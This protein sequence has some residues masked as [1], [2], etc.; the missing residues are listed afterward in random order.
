MLKDLLRTRDLSG[1]DIVRLLDLSAAYKAEPLRHHDTLHG[2]TVVQFFGKPSTRTR[3]SFETAIARLGGSAITTGP[4]DLQLGRG[5][6]IE[7]TARTISQYA[8]AFVIRT[9]KDDDVRR[10]AAAA[11]IPV[12]NALTD[13]HHPCQSLADLLTLRERFGDVTECR[14]AYVGDGYNVA[15]SLLEA[16]ALLGMDIA[17][18]TPPGYEPDRASIAFATA[19]AERSGA[20]VTITNDPA[21]AA[22]G[23]HAVYTDV[24]FSMGDTELERASRIATFLPYRVDPALMA[25]ARPDAVFMHCLPAHRGEEVMA[26]V[27]DGPQSVVFPQAAN[28]L[29]TAQA[30]LYALATG[31]LT[32]PDAS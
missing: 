9:F 24:W 17:V 6:T 23:A 29:P 21:E 31:A 8:R 32:G 11:A 28:R 1:D 3:I 12:V 22:R 26:A 20:R 19:E 27:I 18:A 16:A 13:G 5:E 15:N 10:F 25:H 14:L 30:V 2:E 4:N 7:D